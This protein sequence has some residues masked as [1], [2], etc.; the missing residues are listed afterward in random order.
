MAKIVQENFGE[1]IIEA[2]RGFANEDL[3]SV[4]EL[5]LDEF[6]HVSDVPLR[7][8]LAATFY[9]ARWLYKVG[10]ALL[11]RDAEQMAHVRAQVMDYGAVCEGLLSDALLHALTTARMRGAKHKLFDFNKPKAIINWQVA[12]KLNKLTRQSFYWHIEVAEEEGIIDATLS[13]QLHAM[14]EER[15]TVHMR[16][17][18]YKAFLSTS[19][20]LFKTTLILIKQTKD[21]RKL[22][23]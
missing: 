13:R 21:W 6:S 11:V 7:Q 1:K 5:Q 4:D 9:G 2:V 14:R 17:R 8:M 12:N 23:P 22:N 10:L 18:T 20:S 19:K 15:N 16:A 3:K